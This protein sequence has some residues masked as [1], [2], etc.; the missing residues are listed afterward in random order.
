VPDALNQNFDD[1]QHQFYHA[2]FRFHPEEAVSIGQQG[3]A[4]LLRAYGDDDIGAL[5]S[6]L[7]KMHSALDELDQ[8]GLSPDRVTDYELMKA[9]VSV[10]CHDL[11]ELDWRYRNPLPYVPVQAV[12]QLLIHPIPELETAITQRLQ[13]IPQYLRGARGFLSQQPARV[14]PIWL[15]SAVQQSEI[16]AGFVRSLGRH[17]LLAGKLTS[18]ASLQPLLDDAAH[19][20]E[21]FARFLQREIAHRAAGD[22]AVGEDRFNRL[23]R[24]RHGLDV[25]AKTLLAFGQRLFD[26]TE[27]ELKAQAAR[28]EPGAGIDSLLDRI[29]R[30]HPQPA[31]L[32]DAYRKRMR[33]ARL[34]LSEH[35][36]VTLPAHESLHIQETPAFLRPLIPFAAYEPP[37]PVDAEQR[38]LYYVTTPDQENLLAEH[39]RYSIDLTSVHESYPGHHLQFVTANSQ[40]ADNITR[41]IHASASMYEGW[42]LYCEDLMHEH[43]FLNEDAHRFI[44]LRDRLWRA[45]R[46]IIDVSIQTRG[47]SLGDAAELMVDKLGFERQQADAEL[48]WYTTEPTIPLCYATGYELIK[49]VR[50][51]QQSR[52]GFDQKTF[53]DALLREGSIALPLVIKTAFGEQAWRY[54]REKVFS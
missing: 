49:A 6:L 16:G 32:L 38:G 52:S 28:M 15:Q 41:L 33:A 8:D 10:E 17:P 21:D 31:Q 25:G 36:L 37:G 51:Y 7:Q 18:P 24:E 35:D 27:A 14:V 3:F 48:A 4:G 45:L 39:N 53:H 47:M 54:A 43:G 12:N 46:V 23:L 13:T 30:Q 26:A 5:T 20:L 29:K 50:E 11:Q 2:W 1:L 42:A 34:W 19:A 40:H 44:M 9:A 22:F